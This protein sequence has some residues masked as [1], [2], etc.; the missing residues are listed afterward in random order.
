MQIVHLGSVPSTQQV[1]CDLSL[2]T[3]VVADHQSAGRGRLQRAWEAP[4]GTALLATFVLAPRPLAVF[5]AGVAAAEACGPGIRLKWPNDLLLDGRK[6]AGL[7]AEQHGDRCLVGIGINLSWSPPGAAHLG[8]SRDDLL[9]RLVGSV[10]AWW[11]RHDRDVLDA[12]RRRS[13]T[14]GRFVRAELPSQTL[15][16]V[17]E[18]I[19]PDGALVV[20][21]HRVVVGDVVHLNAGAGDPSGV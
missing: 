5:C 19:D 2:G 17:A 1:A 16:G 15:E 4:P 8:V 11:S 18:A 7:L 3:V 14:L 6:L 13:D 10:E 12:W 9:P 20:A 21:G